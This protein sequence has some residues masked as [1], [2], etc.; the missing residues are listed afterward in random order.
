MAL[1]KIRWQQFLM[2]N[3]ERNVPVFSNDAQRDAVY[4]R[5]EER[6]ACGPFDGGYVAVEMALHHIHARELMVVEGRSLSGWAAFR[7]PE[8]RGALMAQHAVVVFPDGTAMDA[9]GRCSVERMLRR[10]ARLTHHVAS[11][12][13]IRALQDGDLEDAPRDAALIHELVDLLRPSPSFDSPT[14]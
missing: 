12:E 7:Q 3:L 1:R 9:D 5:M 13:G 6:I 10:T 8:Y 2:A 14:P 4:Q 11:V